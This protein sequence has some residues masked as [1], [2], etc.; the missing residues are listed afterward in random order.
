MKKE[1]NPRRGAG[2]VGTAG[3]A[4][5]EG[6]FRLK[7]EKNPR[8]GAEVVDSAELVSVDAD[9]AGFAPA[10]DPV[11]GAPADDPVTAAPADDPAS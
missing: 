8:R 10:D 9:I 1:K 3:F 5:A 4:L 11:T 6:L 2:V 7:K